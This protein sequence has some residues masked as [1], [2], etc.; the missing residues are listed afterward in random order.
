MDIVCC[1]I[2]EGYLKEHL[3]FVNMLNP[4]NAQKQAYRIHLCVKLVCDDGNDYYISLRNNL[5][6]DVRLFGRISHA[7]PSAKRQIAGMHLS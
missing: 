5:G 7:I 6:D 3:D 4:G 2:K 1:Y